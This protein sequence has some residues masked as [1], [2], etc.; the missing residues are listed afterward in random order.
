MTVL[1]VLVA[2][3]AAQL[4]V[5]STAGLQGQTEDTALAEQAE[6]AVVVEQVVVAPERDQA[7]ADQATEVL[8]CVDFVDCN[9]LDQP[10]LKVGAAADIGRVVDQVLVEDM[11]L[12]DQDLAVGTDPVDHQGL[13][14]EM[15]AC[16]LCWP[17]TGERVPRSRR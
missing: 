6:P 17:G 9:T 4:G 8:V 5:D 14:A 2:R 7:R 13:A 15:V 3:T 12:E 11:G 16:L 1:A 10:G